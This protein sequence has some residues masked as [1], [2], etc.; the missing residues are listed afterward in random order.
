MPSLSGSPDS[1]KERRQP[2]TGEVEKI[3]LG[4]WFYRAI[5][6]R[7]VRNSEPI[8]VEV[9]AVRHTRRGMVVVLKKMELVSHFPITS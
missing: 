4:R 5:Q 9:H 7:V 2:H 3:M 6:E 1:I 8:A